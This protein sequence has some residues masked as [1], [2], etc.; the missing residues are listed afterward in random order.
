MAPRQEYAASNARGRAEEATTAPPSTSIHVETTSSAARGVSPKA[1]CPIS[2]LA[3][4]SWRGVSA[5]GAPQP[6]LVE[7]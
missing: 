6:P 1:E 7:L 5:K 3:V 2:T 4:A